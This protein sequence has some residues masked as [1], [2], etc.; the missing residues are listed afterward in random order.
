MSESD[1]N[2]NLVTSTGRRKPPAAGMGRPKGSKNKLSSTIKDAIEKA[3][4]KA[5]GV[6]YLVEMARA[7]P[8]AF[9][10]LLAKVLPTQ[11]EHSNPDGTMTPRPVDLSSL[12]N[13]AL[14]E[15]IAARDAANK[16]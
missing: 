6:E 10:G 7:Q 1:K 13:E 16:N 4:D 15:L 3:F 14:A 2:T 5:G 8:A 11:L 9:M 12:S